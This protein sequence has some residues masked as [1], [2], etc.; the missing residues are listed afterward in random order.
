MLLMPTLI[1]QMGVDM[2]QFG[3]LRTF[4]MTSAGPGAP[5]CAEPS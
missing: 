4:G 1:I 2:L 5:N 3:I